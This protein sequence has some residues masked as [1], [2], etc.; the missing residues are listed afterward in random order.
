[1]VLAQ[2]LNYRQDPNWR[3]PAEAA[4]KKNPLSEQPE[5]AAGGKKLFTRIC[6]ECHG[7]S[8]E[9]VK[10]N[11]ADLQLSVVQAQSDGALFWKITNGNLDR[12]MPSFSRLT[13]VQ[14]WQIVLHLRTLKATDVNR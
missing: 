9:G 3:V 6:V 11:A 1:M 8:G 5:L 2:N 13:E 4:T 12:G 14:R 10:R 7:R